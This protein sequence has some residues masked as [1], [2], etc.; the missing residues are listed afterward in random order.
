MTFRRLLAEAKYDMDSLTKIWN[1]GKREA[2]A[3]LVKKIEEV[4]EDEREE[5]VELLDSHFDPE[6][7][8]VKP[9]VQRR[10]NKSERGN[11]VRNQPPRRRR[12]APRG[13]NYNKENMGSRSNSQPRRRKHS[14]DKRMDNNNNN[15][16]MEPPLKAVH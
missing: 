12:G 16:Q 1:E 14:T 9:V 7:K 2:I 15:N 11:N 4:K 8:A 6:K 3:D 13:R 5:L 10:E